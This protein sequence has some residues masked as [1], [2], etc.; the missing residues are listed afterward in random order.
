V[1]RSHRAEFFGLIKHYRGKI[2]VLEYLPKILSDCGFY[3]D[4]QIQKFFPTPLTLTLPP[5]GGRGDK[6]KKLLANHIKFP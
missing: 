4:C 6:R 3:F 5:G 2:K 1:P